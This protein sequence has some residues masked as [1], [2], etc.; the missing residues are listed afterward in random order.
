MNGRPPDWGLGSRFFLP[1]EDAAVVREA[2]S[3]LDAP[4]RSPVFVGGSGMVLLEVAGA[5]PSL[6]RAAFVDIA[7]FQLE[8]FREV[9]QAITL[10]ESP[11]GLRRWFLTSV[12]PRLAAHFRGRGRD[13]PA[14]RV[15]EALSSR[16]GVTFFFDPE[17][18]E[19]VLCAVGKVDVVRDDIGAYLAGHSD[20][21]DFVYLSNVPDYMFPA[22][23]KRIFAA[24]RGRRAPVYL[25]VTAACPD[26]DGLRRIWSEA[27]YAPH[28][29][30]KRLNRDNRGLGAPRLSAD[31]NRPGEIFL[32]LPI[33]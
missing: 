19:R 30:T 12:Y 4:V 9:I 1:N 22:E 25:L 7:S 2:A 21:H 31:W 17:A 27:G 18:L 29:E 6:E 13:Y 33:S 16:F 8:Y 24:C 20:T 3:L 10:A 14:D 28:P 15:M 11:E 5:L 32:L 23:S 26:P